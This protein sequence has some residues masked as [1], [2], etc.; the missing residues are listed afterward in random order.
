MDTPPN[1]VPNRKPWRRYATFASVCVIVVA[2]VL[3][4]AVVTR[5]RIA[6]NQRAWFVARLDALI[7]ADLRDNDI[8]ADRVWVVDPDLLGTA[9]PV[10]IYRARKNGHAVAAILSA[11][12]PEGYGGAI[13]LL[14]SVNYE[15]SVL[16]VDIL[17]HN[18]TRGIGD[19]FAPHRS[20]WLRS[21]VG[22]SL[23]DTARNRWTIRKDGGDFEQFTG[24][25][26]TP[27]AILKAVRNALEYY[28]R[29]RDT[30]F[31]APADAH[32][33]QLQTP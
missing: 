30:I 16:A 11:T 23:T 31:S 27:R 12:A 1:A 32:A 3:A 26:I 13:E 17:R 14:I 28:S 25:S 18:E 22:R 21:L 24:A 19:G 20:D 4:I 7:P 29:H 5:D 6:A 2:T 33:N 15:G 10:A 9:K 8:Y